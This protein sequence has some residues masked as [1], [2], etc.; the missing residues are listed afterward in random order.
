M[1]IAVIVAAALATLLCARSASAQDWPQRQVTI[2]V[3]FTAGGT[4]DMFTMNSAG[5]VKSFSCSTGPGVQISAGAT[6]SRSIK[7]TR[8]RQRSRKM[9]DSGVSHKAAAMGVA[10][11]GS[12]KQKIYDDPHGVA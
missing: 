1:R 11:G 6:R 3:P 7:P 12:M 4:T 10:A 5:G 9:S 8:L 2:V